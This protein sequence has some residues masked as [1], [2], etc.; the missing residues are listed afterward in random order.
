M[1]QFD[2]R[3]V[4]EHKIVVKV[5]S[6]A[7][8]SPLFATEVI[9]HTSIGHATYQNFISNRF[10][11][12]ISVWSPMQKRNLKSFKGNNKM[13]K[14][15]VDNKV[16]QLREEKTARF[17]ITAQKRP[18]LNLEEALGNFEFSVVPKALFFN[19]GQPL[20]CTGKSTIL[21]HIEELLNSQQDVAINPDISV[22]TDEQR[23][24]IIDVMAVANQINKTK[25]IKSCKVSNISLNW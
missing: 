6:K 3:F 9:N 8:L 17:L 16:V 23:V 10:R 14:K 20:N 25:E 4:E 2:I 15:N 24:S 18:E 11:G 5:I 19:D 13:I 7:V 22:T 21:H 12:N 1:D